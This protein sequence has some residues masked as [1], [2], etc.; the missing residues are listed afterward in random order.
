MQRLS[1]GYQ[2]G[3]KRKGRST[4]LTHDGWAVNR[5]RGMLGFMTGLS[6]W[7]MATEAMSSLINLLSASQKDGAQLWWESTRALQEESWCLLPLYCCFRV[8]GGATESRLSEILSRDQGGEQRLRVNRRESQLHLVFVSLWHSLR[9]QICLFPSSL[10]IKKFIWQFFWLRK[11]H[12][13]PPGFTL[14][15][16]L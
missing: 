5:F 14:P 10:N 3:L 1:G 13:T 7:H 8:M 16:D 9:L 4:N 15:D 11:K 6:L 2:V 12:S